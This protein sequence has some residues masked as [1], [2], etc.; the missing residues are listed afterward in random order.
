M[1]TFDSIFPTFLTKC[2]ELHTLLLSVAFAL[3]IVGVIVTMM[4]RSSHR[5]I[6]HL[7]LRLLLLTSLLVF[8]PAW[9]NAIQ[10][11]LQDSILSGLGV[12][13]ANVYKEF[14]Q[15]LVV[16]RAPT[17]TGSWWYI[18]SQLH[19]ITTDI[20]VTVALYIIGLL[21][22]A[23]MYWGYIVQKIILNLGYALSPLLIGFMA[24]PA[25]KHTGNRY[26]M[27]LVGV[28]LWPLGWAVAAL[29]TQGMLDLMTNPG[30]E[31]I[32]PTS[33]LPDLQKTWGAALIGF[34]IVFS[35]IAAPVIIQKVISSGALAGSELLS[36]GARVAIQTATSAV[37]GAVAAAPLGPIAAVA[38][39]GAAGGLTL[40]ST[41]SATGHAGSMVTSLGGLAAYKNDPT[42]Q[43]AV[44]R[45]LAQLARGGLP[46]ILPK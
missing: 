11:L 19:N 27:N 10:Q 33:N 4:H 8:L 39:G 20:L 14:V 34:W 43:K 7:L 41:S 42:G 35:T 31:F 29:I 40:L 28:L 36:G 38:A 25:L 37:S 6:L 18:L 16:S 3:L 32:D 2:G 23:M 24:I 17:M 46:P 22:S 13:P 9:G 30:F 5:A 12:D 44:H 26:L 21:A 1:P 15:L 45:L